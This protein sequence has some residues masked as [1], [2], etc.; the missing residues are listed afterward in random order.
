[1][2]I[3]ESSYKG[4]SL[5]SVVH[6][7]RLQSIIRTIR[8]L[9]FP[10]DGQFADFGCSNGFLF[11]VLLNSI[12]DMRLMTI[13]GFDHSEELLEVA[14]LRNLERAIFRYLDLN[15]PHPAFSAPF[16][17]VTCFETL[18]HVG[19]TT[20]AL[21]T[22]IAAC[23]DGG[24]IVL[25][26]PNETGIPGLIKYVGRRVLRR[27]PYGDFFDKR[28]EL[29]YIWHLLV[30]K[31]IGMFRNPPAASWGPHLGFDWRSVDSHLRQNE[32]CD[33]TSR[34]SFFFGYIYVIKKL[35]TT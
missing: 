22:L 16:D 2:I 1:M 24:T 12:P 26:L 33:I 35:R 31:S 34:N 25:S 5:S 20:N 21:K 11:E 6:R 23:K 3:H 8:S 29:R 4:A 17:L 7:L 13:F 9:S 32:I 18:E 30:G 28:S 15:L 19:D 10:K 27:N 14:R